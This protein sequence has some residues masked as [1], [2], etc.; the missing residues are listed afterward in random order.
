MLA[1]VGVMAGML[2]MLG[3]IDQVS[4]QTDGVRCEIRGVWLERASYSPM[5]G[6]AEMIYTYAGG[7]AIGTAY[8]MASISMTENQARLEAYKQAKN[9]AFGQIGKEVCK[10]RS[11][12]AGA[13]K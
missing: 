2:I 9:D 13:H 8:V 11:E 10:P 3:C 4:A 7:H 6:K 12:P 5:T 1:I